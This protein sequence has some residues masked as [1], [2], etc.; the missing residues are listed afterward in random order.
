M[1]RVNYAKNGYHLNI[2]KP[3]LVMV[4]HKSENKVQ[5]CE[6]NE[7]RSDTIRDLIEHF[8]KTYVFIDTSLIKMNT[9]SNKS[10]LGTSVVKAPRPAPYQIPAQKNNR[11]FSFNRN[12]PNQNNQNKNKL[13]KSVSDVSANKKSQS[14]EISQGNQQFFFN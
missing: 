5:R 4:Y 12:P 2:N 7:F 6:F 11:N 9:S 8:E 14:N 1:L 13:V 3:N 10:C